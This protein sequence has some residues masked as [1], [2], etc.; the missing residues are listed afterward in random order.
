MKMNALQMQIFSH[1]RD[2][3]VDEQKKVEKAQ[4]EAQQLKEEYPGLM[5]KVMENELTSRK[6]EQI[7]EEAALFKITGPG[8]FPM[9]REEVAGEIK[10]RLE[11]LRGRAKAVEAG[12]KEKAELIK[13]SQ[14]RIVNI[15]NEFKAAMQKS[16]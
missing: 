16:G 15:D 6:V 10:G 13:N 2:R 1:F 7:E 14:E 12:L 9:R 8:L 5:Q 11:L 3:M 4:A